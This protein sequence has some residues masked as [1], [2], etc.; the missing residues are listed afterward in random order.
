[1]THRGRRVFALFL[2][3]ALAALP[4]ARALALG[5]DSTT[6]PPSPIPTRPDSAKASAT[7][8]PADS[9]ALAPPA[10]VVVPFDSTKVGPKV[11]GA[12]TAADSSAAAAHPRASAGPPYVPDPALEAL[13]LFRPERTADVERVSFGSRADPVEPPGLVSLAT[14]LRLSPGVR[15]REMSQGPNV[16]TFDLGGTGS[17]RSALLFRGTP[18]GVPGTSGPESD[19]I[20]LS[21]IDG[22]SVVR[23]GAAA[24]YGP[25]AADGAV[26]ASP[27]APLPDSLLSRVSAEEG[28]DDWQRGAF[29]TER[30][31]GSGAGF[32][33]SAESRRIEGF[34]PGTKEVDRQVA[35]TL[36]G[37]LPFGFE[38]EAGVRVFHGDGRQGGFDPGTIRPVFTKRN[39]L[40]AKLFHAT[41]A[42]GVLLE[43]GLLREKLETGIGGATALTRGYVDP[44]LVVTADLPKAAGLLWT[45]RVQGE[46]YRV[47]RVEEQTLDRFFRGAAAL[48]AT[49]RSGESFVTATGRVD[50]EE[51][52]PALP[53]A[54]LEGELRLGRLALFSVVSR[55]RRLPDRSALRADDA[56]TQ[57]TGQAGARLTAGPFL[58]RGLV[59]ATNV[60]DLR[61]EPTFE[62]IRSRTPV[63]DLPLGD[64]RIRGGTFGLDSQRFPM[65]GVRSLGDFLFRTSVTSM[66][67]E[68]ASGARL[69]G[70]PRL[71]WTGEGFLERHFF[72]GELLARLRGRLTYEHDRVD[73]QGAPVIDAWV[74]DVQA[75]GEVGDAVFFYRFLDLL[76]RADEIE[77]GIRLPGFS[78]MWGI[79]WRFVG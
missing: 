10:H 29:Q 76:D 19:E 52:R 14:H 41:R 31:I 70:R 48:R 8:S 34:F 77:P 37:R 64:A 26:I 28:V 46:R 33:L 69:P 15:T 22:F 30:R 72:Q 5:A 58:L 49:L 55:E 47:E 50:A 53:Q 73:D 1:M 79:T 75:E 56:E 57:R 7:K 16:E 66:S 11:Q 6:A 65:P 40:H 17:G 32:F 60:D 68:L 3:V 71:S 27:R 61:R 74:T 12:K 39:D 43:A 36:V 20:V 44:S 13:S 63:V 67:A 21:E 2:V 62:E 59:F 35:G 23:G 24:L 38:G 25:D 18:F 42:G 45:A 9:S 78:R 51:E 4:L 54:R